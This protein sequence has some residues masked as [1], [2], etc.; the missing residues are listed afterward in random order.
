MIILIIKKEI[1]ESWL[2]IKTIKRCRFK[3]T[4][5][6]LKWYYEKKGYEVEVL[7]DEGI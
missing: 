3:I 6:I 7:E 5:K 1:V 4:A 2:S